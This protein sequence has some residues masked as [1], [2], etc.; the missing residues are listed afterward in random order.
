MYHLLNV[1]THPVDFSAASGDAA[2]IEGDEQVVLE[3]G[4]VSFSSAPLSTQLVSRHALT[5]ITQE[6]ELSTESLV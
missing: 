3:N 6:R 2:A 5:S 4:R 1:Q